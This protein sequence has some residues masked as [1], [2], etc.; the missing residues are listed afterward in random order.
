MGGKEVVTYLG[1]HVDQDLSGKSMAKRIIHKANASLKFLY[2]KYCRKTVC[3]A[4]IQSRIDYA[5]NFY[6]HGLPKFL[7]SRLQVVQSKMIRYVLNYSNRTYLV[8]NDFN[9]VKWMSIENR[10]K[11]LAASHVFNC[12]DEQAPEYLQVFERVNESHHYNT[13]HSVNALILPKVGSYGIKSFHYIGAKICNSLPDEIQTMSSKSL[14]KMRCKKHF[15]SVQ[16][17][18]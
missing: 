17:E 2:R 13:R 4:I 5:S 15:I 11:Y 18:S 14:F 6:Y 8:A 10:I 3:M 16:S 7:Q 9:E 12:I 1:G